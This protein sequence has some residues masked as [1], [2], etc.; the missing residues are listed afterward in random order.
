MEEESKSTIRPGTILSH[1]QIL[2]RLGGGA[3]ADVYAAQDLSLGRQVA[4]KVP[5]AEAFDSAANEQL[6]REARAASGLN[7]PN[8]AQI[9]YYEE[10]PSGRCFIVMELAKGRTLREILSV[11][12]LDW[13]RALKFAVRIAE[14]LESAH[15]QG[16]IHR[17]IKPGNVCISETDTLKVLDFGLARQPRLNRPADE[18]ETST[19]PGLVM[20]TLP[21]MSPEQVQG[22]EIDETSDLWS[23]GVLLYECL[24]G[25]RPFEGKT[26]AE[27]AA[28]ILHKDPLP[29]SRLNREVSK[30]VDAIVRRLLKKRREE[31]YQNAADVLRDLRAAEQESSR[32]WLNILIDEVKFGWGR[33]VAAGLAV[34]VIAGGGWWYYSQKTGYA[35]KAAA[36]QSFRRGL[37]Y[38]QEGSFESAIKALE[39]AVTADPDFAVAHA[40]MAEALLELGRVGQARQEMLKARPP[41]AKR[42]LIRSKADDF[43]DAVHYAALADRERSL[44]LFRQLVEAESGE[45]RAYAELDL[46]R[47]YSRA[48]NPKEALAS[49]DRALRAD[50]KSAAAYLRKGI[51][52]ASQRA[53]GAAEALKEARRLFQAN[54]NAEGEAEALLAEGMRLNLSMKPV[55]AEQAL[56]EALKISEA[57][58][59]EQ[60]TLRIKMQMADTLRLARRIDEAEKV[61]E[62][63][64]DRAKGAGN[65]VILVRALIT[66]ANVRSARGMGK[67]VVEDYR[68][69]IREADRFGVINYAARARV[70]LSTIVGSQDPK[71][72]LALAEKAVE[73][74]TQD[75]R[76]ETE[77]YAYVARGRARRGLR[78]YDGARAD[79]LKAAGIA[80]RANMRQQLG[81]AEEG[82]ASL[83]EREERYPQVMEKLAKAIA[84]LSEQPANAGYLHIR[85]ARA[86]MRMGRFEEARAELESAKTLAGEQEVRLKSMAI[87][88]EAA[89]DAISGRPADAL[90]RLDEAEG[91]GQ[92]QQ[93]YDGARR[94]YAAAALMMK[95]DG[96]K[97]VKECDEAESQGKLDGGLRLACA[98]AALAARDRERAQRWARAAQ[99]EA[100]QFKKIESEWRAW[101]ILAQADPAD[102]GARDRAAL[103]LE[104][105][106]QEWG[107]EAFLGF[108][109][110]PDVPKR[111]KGGLK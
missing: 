102:A 90:R 105:L 32:T 86:A 22:L 51:L 24:T 66:R 54:S 67:Q 9:F 74:G 2:E 44:E 26:T 91:A 25:K 55:E 82:L 98:E 37:Q 65:E 30:H 16:V 31:R 28:E 47:A 93:K 111:L 108:A 62:E 97:A 94:E 69:A 43:V 10:T 14:A 95:G 80:E 83:L 11:G 59:N 88:E 27:L 4:L 48:G 75:A 92:G 33:W 41:D 39:Q 1:Y 73:Q 89:L 101:Q 72:A 46:C 70:T 20:G 40:R 96:A 106:K 103:S 109:A 58:K 84:L 77:G 50:P 3:F 19:S 7:H 42:P 36:V 6:K 13:R 76:I 61:A 64:L 52:L 5:K 45:S 71:E 53:P 99:A 81:F 56:D 57:V 29:P 15:A 18:T 78:D 85:R 34:A 23:L 68:Q 63:V 110:R 8:I 35:P 87:A 21:Y 17:D 107:A 60:Q 12:K 79:F 49:C 100:E 38:I 104:R